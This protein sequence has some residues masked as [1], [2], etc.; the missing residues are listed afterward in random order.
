MINGLNHKNLDY[1]DI[2]SSIDLEDLTNFLVSLTTEEWVPTCYWDNGNIVT[3]PI[4]NGTIYWGVYSY[5]VK[6][7]HIRIENPFWVGRV[8]ARGNHPNEYFE[9]TSYYNPL[10]DLLYRPILMRL[11]MEN[12]LT[13]TDNKF[14]IKSLVVGG[15]RYIKKH[16]LV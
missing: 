5:L 13:S 10:G 1:G 15:K 12:Y 2:V 16:K 14:W 7:G 8:P 11:G 9:H 3:K 4:Q 6:N